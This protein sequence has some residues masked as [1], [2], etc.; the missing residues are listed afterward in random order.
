MRFISNNFR[1]EGSLIIIDY[2]YGD[3]TG[4]GTVDMVYLLGTKLNEDSPYVENIKLKIIEGATNKETTIEF[5]NEGGYNFSL[6]LGDFNGDKK[7]EILIRGDTGGSGGYTYNHIISYT[8][9]E[10]K[11]IFNGED[12]E[13]EYKYSA[14]YKDNFKLEVTSINLNKRYIV[15]L[16]DSDKFYLNLV[17]DDK[18]ILKEPTEASVSGINGLIPTDLNPDKVYRIYILQRIIGQANADNLGVVQTWMEWDGNKFR[19]FI[20]TVGVL[21]GDIT[22]EEPKDKM[23]RKYESKHT[24][25]IKHENKEKDK[26]KHRKNKASKMIKNNDLSIDFKN[27]KDEKS[28]P[29]LNKRSDNIETK[30]LRPFPQ[31]VTYRSGTIRPTGFKQEQLD[32]IVKKLYDEWKVKYLKQNVKIPEQYYVFYNLEG[33]L[34]P[35]NA[36]SVSE[37]HGHGMILTA[38]M[39]GYDKDAKKYF[40]GLYRFYKAHPS[41]NNPFLMSWQQVIDPSGNIIDTTDDGKDSAT[42]G[43]MDIAYALLLADKQWGSKGEIDYL[44]EGKKIINAILNSDVNHGL[45]SLKLGDWV[46]DNNPKYGTGTRTSDFM[47]D[48]LRAFFNVTADNNWMKVINKTYSIAKELYEKFAPKTGLLP[49]FALMVKGEYRPAPPNYLEGPYDGNYNWNACRTPWRLPLDYLLLGVNTG[50]PLLTKLNTWVRAKTGEDPSKIRAG[51]YLNGEDLPN[52]A[53]NTLAFVA[54]FA[55][56]AMIDGKNQQWLNKLWSRMNNPTSSD[57]YYYSRT[58]NLLCSI[59]LSGNWWF[60]K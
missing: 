3:V 18:G 53:T 17:Y 8:H 15:D 58:I 29:S 46:E 1:S 40:D 45:W 21:G 55:V 52:S 2:K 10:Y 60:P 25:K 9:G 23:M 50:I 11:E 30:V 4:E 31:H 22:E 59:V 57:D 47:L 32:N 12:F 36:V 26:E 54:P 41:S 20:Q 44:K 39:A 49:D 16:T 24:S 5:E 14:V 37:S 43:D 51:Y 34:M 6:F 38:L 35:K 48:H 27:H 56:S 28:K 42:D 19:T 7:D 33:I 13:R